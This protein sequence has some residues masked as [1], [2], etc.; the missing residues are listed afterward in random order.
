MTTGT[1]GTEFH[2]ETEPD[3]A[4]PTLIEGL[5]GHGLVASIAVDQITDQLDLEQYGSIRSDSFPP[6]TSFANGRVQ[7]TVRVYGGTDPDVLT[8]QSDI[9]IPEDAFGELSRCVLEELVDDFGRAIFL[10]GA[11][12]QS[13]EQ[14]GDVVG[15][16]TTEELKTELEDA[17]VDLM[18][19]SGA[20]GGVT[21]A[22]V[23]AC[24][25]ADVPAVLLLVR[26]DPR[27]PDPAAAQSVIE[28]ALEPLV[29]FE[30]DADPLQK[31][32]ENIQQQKQQVAQQLQQARGQQDEPMQAKGMFR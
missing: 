27:L 1:S 4:E 5:P 17:G 7:D 23:N 14:Q 24:Y 22:L 18:E 26:A 30:I 8:L 31:Q 16:A 12:A 29:E 9:P 3:A 20:V 15:V 2:R 13:E 11:P 10:A 19:D 28:T 21:G 32:A 25:Q 6:V